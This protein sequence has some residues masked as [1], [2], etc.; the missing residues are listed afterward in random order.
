[1]CTCIWIAERS[2]FWLGPAIHVI[3]EWMLLLCGVQERQV[4]MPATHAFGPDRANTT[5]L[6]CRRLRVPGPGGHTWSSC[7]PEHQPEGMQPVHLLKARQGNGVASRSSIARHLGTQEKRRRRGWH[8]YV[9][10]CRPRALL[11]SWR[12]P[13]PT[14]LVHAS[15]SR[16]TGRPRSNTI[17]HGPYSLYDCSLTA[18]LWVQHLSVTAAALYP[19]TYS[20]ISLVLN[21]TL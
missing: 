19:A 9:A 12:R 17:L 16:V 7:F 20:S 14:L 8:I 6:Q 18:G 21:S 10:G 2:G 3:V 1:M 5:C 15:E 11:H 4:H 13:D